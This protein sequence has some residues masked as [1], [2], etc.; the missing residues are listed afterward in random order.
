MPARTSPIAWSISAKRAFAMAALVRRRLGEFGARRLQHG[1]GISHVRL[2]ADRVADADAGGDG[3]AEQRLGG[4]QKITS[5][6]FLSLMVFPT[7]GKSSCLKRWARQCAGA[8][9]IGTVEPVT[10]LRLGLTGINRHVDLDCPAHRRTI[11]QGFQRPFTV[12]A[13]TFIWSCLRTGPL[14]RGPMPH[15]RHPEI[16]VDRH[17]AEGARRSAALPVLRGIVRALFEHRRARSGHR[18]AVFAP[19]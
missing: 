7:Q 2:R 10:S 15:D 11:C 3:G 12:S 16:A 19:R 6:S 1:N 17:A 14:P 9:R 18:R 13:A 4:Q 5:I 8:G